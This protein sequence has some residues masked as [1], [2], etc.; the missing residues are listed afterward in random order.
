MLITLITNHATKSI[1]SYQN[2]KFVIILT[3]YKSK[4]KTNQY[5]I[6]VKKNLFDTRSHECKHCHGGDCN[7]EVNNYE[8]L[9]F[10]QSYN[11]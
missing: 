2:I 4:H 10:S 8:L 9:Q 7:L 1:L 6:F 5:T 3:N 11:C